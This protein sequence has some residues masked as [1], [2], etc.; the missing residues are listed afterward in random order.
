LLDGSLYFLSRNSGI[1]SNFD[2]KTGEAFYGP[3]RLE[4]IKDVYASPVGADGRVYIVDRDGNAIVLAHGPQ[5]EVLATNS[6]DDG[7]DASPAIV[8][9]ELYLRGKKYLYR[10][11]AE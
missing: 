10:I 7:F 2:A 6:L 8:D 3:E 5:L 1:L 11:S 9:K 4:N